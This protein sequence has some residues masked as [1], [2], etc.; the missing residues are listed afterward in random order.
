MSVPEGRDRGIP[1]RGDQR[2]APGLGCG[3]GAGARARGP[4]W[5]SQ[6]QS[7]LDRRQAAAKLANASSGRWMRLT[8]AMVAATIRPPRPQ[9]TPIVIELAV[10]WPSG[11]N[12]W[13]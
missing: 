11:N 2:Y 5:G 7:R 3:G 12:C 1:A 13:P 8:A 4:G 9:V 10:R 6:A